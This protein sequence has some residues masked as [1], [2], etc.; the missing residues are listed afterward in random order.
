MNMKQSI[1]KTV[2]IRAIAALVSI[3]LFSFVTT[4]IGRAHV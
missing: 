4:E 1:K 2:W 3:L